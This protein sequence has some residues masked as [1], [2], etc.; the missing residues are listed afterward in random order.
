MF[1]PAGDK[2]GLNE[3]SFVSRPFNLT[4]VFG[5]HISCVLQAAGHCPQLFWDLPGPT[6]SAAGTSPHVHQ[7]NIGLTFETAQSYFAT[8]CL[9]LLLLVTKVEDNQKANFCDHFEIKVQ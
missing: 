3:H 1:L 6:H 9:Y 7:Q 4:V 2:R 8:C 5:D